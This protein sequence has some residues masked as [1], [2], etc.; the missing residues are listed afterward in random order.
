MK[1]FQTYHIS[2]DHK[3]LSLEHYLKTILAYSGRTIQKLTRLNGIKL[4]NKNVFL[5]RR[6]QQGDVLA[7]RIPDDRSYGVL[8]E[9]GPVDIL[10][11]DQGV[12]V[13]NKPPHLLVHPAGHTSTGTLANFLAGYFQQKGDV[14]TI[15]PLHRLDRDTSGCIVFAKDSRTQT[16]LEKGLSDGRFKRTYWSV[17]EGKIEPASGIIDMPIG[18]HPTLPNRRAV[19]INGER[20]LTRYT[21]LKASEKWTLLELNLETGRTHQIR[22][23]F[24]HFGH[25]VVGDKMYGKRSP[26]I[27][28]QALHAKSVT[29][30]HPASGQLIEVQAPLPPDLAKVIDD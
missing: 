6:L 13:L 14:I 23:H 17:V 19:D 2:E 18:P 21:T 8:P 11:E 25:A 24:A 3:G 9:K 16:F 5:Q 12:I 28:R 30:V 1:R 10:Y 29:F 4:N 22:V 26:L 20:A 7:V 15:R 27:D